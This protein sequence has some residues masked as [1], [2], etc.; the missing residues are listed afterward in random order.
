LRRDVARCINLAWSISATAD[1]A[2]PWAADRVDPATRMLLRYLYRVIAVSPT[3]RA[4]SRAL[5][6]INQMVAPPQAVLRPRVLVSA[7]RGSRRLPAAKAAPAR[8]GAS[9][10]Q[11]AGTSMAGEQRTAAPL[12][13][14]D[15]DK[16]V[17]WRNRP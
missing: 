10:H 8:P 12:T 6:D 17:T 3:S 9:S 13:T 15:A 7:I 1:L 14:Y 11:P 5:L 16:A 4:A 2:Y